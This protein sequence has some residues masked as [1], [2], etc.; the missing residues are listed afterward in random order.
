MSTFERLPIKRDLDAPSSSLKPRMIRL[1]HHESGKNPAVSVEQRLLVRVRGCSWTK[2]D[3]NTVAGG[4]IA[5]ATCLLET[6][7]FEIAS[8]PTHST[9]ACRNVMSTD[10]AGS[11]CEAT[12]NLLACAL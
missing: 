3:I 10:V 7:F 11:V 12:T 9:F 5:S 6:F 4:G 2:N 1:E 8:N